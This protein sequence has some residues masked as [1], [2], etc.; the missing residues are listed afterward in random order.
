[1]KK[2]YQI[3]LNFDE[4]ITKDARGKHVLSTGISLSDEGLFITNTNS[5]NITAQDLKY[6][7]I[8]ASKD[9]IDLQDKSIY[10]FPKLNLPRQKVD[11]LKDKFNLKVVRN[12]DKADYHVISHKFLG[13]LFHNNWDTA[14]TFK[15]LYNVFNTWKEN[16]LL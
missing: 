14:I 7:N 4:G 16:N 9:T 15:E 8:V 3:Q 11:L 12:K 6:C 2:F 5:W 13:S 1:M 10:R